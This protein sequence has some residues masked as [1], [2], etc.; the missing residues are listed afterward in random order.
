MGGINTRPALPS[1]LLAAAEE[2]CNRLDADEQ[3]DIVIWH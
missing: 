2:F 1:A 3:P